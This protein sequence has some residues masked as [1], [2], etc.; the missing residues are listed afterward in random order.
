MDIRPCQIYALLTPPFPP[1]V[2]RACAYLCVLDICACV[3]VRARA[4]AGVQARGRARVCMCMCVCVSV[5]MCVRVCVCAQRCVF[6]CMHV[7]VTLHLC[8]PCAHKCISA[9][10]HAL[11]VGMQKHLGVGV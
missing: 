1:V 5:C 8:V 9:N 10:G 3:R 2:T 4:H 7:H 11:H 6:L